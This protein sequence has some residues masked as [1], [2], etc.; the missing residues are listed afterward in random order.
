MRR[1]P[2]AARLAP[3]PRGYAILALWQATLA[4]VFA[5]GLALRG[6]PGS[7]D[8]AVNQI[9]EEYEGS[10]FLFGISLFF[11]MVTALLWSWASSSFVTSMLG[12]T[13]ML[14]VMR[15]LY[16]G[17]KRM[18]YD[19]DFNVEV[20]DSDTRFDFKDA[21]TGRWSVKDD[22]LPQLSAD[23]IHVPGSG[24]RS[25]EAPL[26]GRRPPAA[27]P[28]SP[29]TLSACAPAGTP[30]PEAL[31]SSSVR[32]TASRGKPFTFLW[33]SHKPGGEALPGDG[34]GAPF[35]T[36]GRCNDNPARHQSTA[37]TV[38]SSTPTAARLLPT[39]MH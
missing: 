28:G 2:S 18:F 7:M 20:D 31:R 5:P 25:E 12:T 9:V 32:N 11:F 14:L 19:F 33:Q 6:P 34:G 39:T 21:V 37:A 30:G 26:P 8:M 10:M 23:S 17:V 4:S 24:A 22:G 13:C 29:K 36:G 38:S 3:I 15:T 27:A 1:I 16:G 35:R